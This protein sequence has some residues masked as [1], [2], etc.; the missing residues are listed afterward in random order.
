MAPRTPTE[1]LLAGIW[2][3]LLH[4]ERVGVH[5]NLFE[6]GGHSLLAMRLV[7]RLRQVFDADLPLRVL[8]E[9]P[10]L[11]AL[12]AQIAA[13]HHAAATAPALRRRE[14]PA[15]PPASFAQQRWPCGAG[16]SE[17]HT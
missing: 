11:I 12:A 7:S 8:F 6:L 9:H 5:D 3:E 15:D 14:S 2:A 1:E 4:V 16:R 17:E 13:P 10:T